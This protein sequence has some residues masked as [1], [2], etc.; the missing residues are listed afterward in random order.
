M[1]RRPVG[2]MP[3]ITRFVFPPSSFPNLEP[4][5]LFV[6][7][8]FSHLCIKPVVKGLGESSSRKSLVSG[9]HNRTSFK[10]R[11]D[12][13]CPIRIRIVKSSVYLARLAFRIE[14]WLNYSLLS[15]LRGLKQSGIFCQV[16]SRENVRHGATLCSNGFK[17]LNKSPYRISRLLVTSHRTLLTFGA[18][19]QFDVKPKSR[20]IIR[21]W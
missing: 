6:S 13:P 18:R 20:A 12:R 17:P 10:H 4:L 11:E 9:K 21:R 2:R 15:K 1:C 8:L 3:L 16:L 5:I 14:D 7:G 19:S